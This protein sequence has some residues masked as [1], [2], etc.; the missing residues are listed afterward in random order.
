MKPLIKICGIKSLRH[1]IAA[2]DNGAFW[3]GLVFFKNS[4]RNIRIQEAKNIIKNAPD[5]IL[6]VA[7]TVN[8][9]IML[10]EKL[11]NI[12]IKNFQLHGNETVEYCLFLRNKYDISIFKGIGI[13]SEIDIVKAKKYDKV[14]NWIIF[15]KKDNFLHGGTG[16]TFDWNILNQAKFETDFL[17]SG[18]LTHKNASEALTFTN[19]RGIDVSS[20]VEKKLGQ[21][22]E[23]LISKF[24]NSVKISKG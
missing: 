1:V 2:K 21:K 17:I 4:P 10:I 5:S 20:G 19:A 15:D 14:V 9:N 16:K 23:E 3:Y 22:C 11:L 24:C 7:V 8:P 13:E 6:P 18:G 12:G